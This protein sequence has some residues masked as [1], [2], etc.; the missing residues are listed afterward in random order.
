MKKLTM[1]LAVGALTLS[2]AGIGSADTDINIYGASAQVNFWAGLASTYLADPAGANCT[3]AVKC[4]D[5]A[6][7]GVSSPQVLSPTPLRMAEAPTITA[8]ATLSPLGLAVA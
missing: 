1:A 7:G 6:G 5:G 8:Q 2:L 3:G 4:Y